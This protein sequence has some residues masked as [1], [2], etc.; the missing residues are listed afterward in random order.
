MHI[1]I[2]GCFW[3]TPPSHCRIPSYLLLHYISHRRTL[4]IPSTSHTPFSATYNHSGSFTVLPASLGIRGS[5]QAY[6]GA[7]VPGKYI[8]F[9][10]RKK[11]SLSLI[12]WSRRLFEKCMSNPWGS[13]V[14][15]PSHCY[16]A[17]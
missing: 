14:S 17:G 13:A 12:A 2:D 7:G 16:N 1:L 5:M 11:K 4:S 10:N 15:V 3:N 8:F 9:I 6:T